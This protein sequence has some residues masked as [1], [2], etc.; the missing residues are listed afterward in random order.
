MDHQMGCLTTESEPAQC[1]RLLLL[2]FR[3]R[4]KPAWTD[5]ILYMTAPFVGVR[6]L[7]YTSH[8]QITMS[9]H[10]PVSADFAVDVSYVTFL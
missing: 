2:M 4:R 3:C 7:S 5:R 9:D 8:P 10:R 1:L 6:Q